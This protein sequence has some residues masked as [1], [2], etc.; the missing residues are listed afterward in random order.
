MGFL[1][2]CLFCVVSVCLGFFA[3]LFD[4][5]VLGRFLVGCSIWGIFGFVTVRVTQHWGSREGLQPPSLH[6]V[7]T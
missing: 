4:F 6:V 2:G 1:V 7:K 3:W 5:G